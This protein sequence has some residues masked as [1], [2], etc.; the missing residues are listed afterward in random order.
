MRKK[1]TTMKDVAERVGV[2]RTTV[3]FV[4]NNIPNSNIPEVTR[5]R[6]IQAARE[7]DYAPNAQA[8]NLVKGRTMMIALVVRK[9]AHQFAADAFLTEVMEGVMQVIEPQHFHLMIHAAHANAANNTYRE[10][11]R[12]RK[13]DGLLI[14][15]PLVEDAEVRQL[16]AEGT[17]I[18]LQGAVSGNDIPNVDVDN[19]Q[20]AYAAVQ[21]LLDQGHRRIGHISNAPFSYAASYDRLRGYRQAL[22]EAGIA[23]DDG[24]VQAGNFNDDSGYGPMMALLDAPERPTAV[25]IGSDT[26]ALGALNALRDRH[27]RVPQDISVIGFDDILV[28]QYL[29]PSLTTVHLPAV[30]LG[31]RAGEMILRVIHGEP[32]DAVSVRL[33]T[34]LVI[35]RSTTAVSSE[36]GV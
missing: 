24:L 13:V 20:G 19:V 23:Y 3:S 14:S 8:L 5:Q 33:P 4:L 10:L 25:F 18:V 12:M 7:L 16:H 30:D 9:T 34:H 29:E 1:R 22:S 27:L 32:L 31:R 11:I 21:H 26:V 15:S 35:R 36:K 17:P 6:I 28:G 2:S